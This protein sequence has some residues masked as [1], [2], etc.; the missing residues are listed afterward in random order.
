MQDLSNF[1]GIFDSGVGGLA[2][3][4]AVRA[5]L[6]RE[7]LVYVAD[8]GYAPYGD[9]SPAFIAGRVVALADALVAR[10]ASAI[11]VACNTATVTTIAALRAQGWKVTQGSG[12]LLIRR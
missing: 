1:I 3:H 8:S 2:I 10:G 4:R 5:L 11:V 9:R 12:V 6:P 7:S